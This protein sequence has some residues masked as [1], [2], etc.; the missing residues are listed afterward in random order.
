MAGTPVRRTDQQEQQA[1]QEEPPVQFV[2]VGKEQRRGDGDEQPAHRA[3][4]GDHQVKA[5][6]M[7]RGG[8]ET[9]EFAVAYH[10]ADEKPA[11]VNRHLP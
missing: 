5:G 7:P 11:A 1:G 10:A 6:Q 9:V 2:V 3:A 8:P 4:G